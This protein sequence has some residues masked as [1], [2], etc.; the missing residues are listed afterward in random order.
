[1]PKRDMYQFIVTIL[2][3]LVLILNLVKSIKQLMR[4]SPVYRKWKKKLNLEGYK[5]YGGNGGDGYILK[6]E[7][8][9]SHWCSQPTTHL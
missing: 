3:H 1:M 9:C 6:S 4:L 2:I 5:L 8:E 7:K